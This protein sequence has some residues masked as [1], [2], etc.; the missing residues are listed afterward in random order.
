MRVQQPTIDPP[1]LR[2]LR[3]W[4]P[5][6][7][8]PLM[9]V[10]RFIPGLIDNGPSSIWMIAAFGP[11]LLGLLIVLWWLL[12]SRASWQERNFGLL[13]IGG[14]FAVVASL[15]DKSMIGPPLIVLTAPLGLAGFAVGLIVLRKLLSFKR[16]VFAALVSLLCFGFSGLLQ[17]RRGA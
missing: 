5:T 12:A 2:P 13:A 3:L 10:T 4:I 11:D 9:I 8:V 7:I 17:G 6:I 1:G 15:V 14:T 16:T